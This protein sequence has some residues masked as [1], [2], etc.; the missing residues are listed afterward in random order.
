VTLADGAVLHPCP[1][2]PNCRYCAGTAQDGVDWSFV[3]G[4]F[5]ISLKTRDDRA[6]LVAQQFHKVG[7]CRKVLFYRPE[8]HP[9][10]GT[11]GSWESHRAVARLALERGFER[12]L[13]F[14]DDVLFVGKLSPPRLH[15][16]GDTLDRLPPDWRLLFLGHWPL[17]AYFVRPTVLRCA[18][19]CAH[20]YISSKTQLQWLAERPHGT[21]GIDKFS[22]VGNTLDAAFARLPGAY[23]LFPMIAIQSVSQSDN[24]QTTGRPKKKVK[25]LVSRSRYRE[26]LLSNFMR[27]AQYLV[28]LGSPLAWFWQRIVRGRN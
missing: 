8:K 21:P 23:A 1:T 5:C 4:A 6:T 7:L 9:V 3:D 26:W 28:V 2:D 17:W 22:I 24:F 19:A 13:T 12:A 16:I 27:P 14:E 10:K 20:A 18:S 15:A 11:I 25:H